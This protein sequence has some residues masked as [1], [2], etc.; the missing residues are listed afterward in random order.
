MVPD[1]V[2]LNLLSPDE[3]RQLLARRLGLGRIT[4]EPA[5]AD[6][7][8]EACAG[9]PLA[10]AVAAARA[11]ASPRLMLAGLAEE[12]QESRGGLDALD[13]GESQTNVRAVFSW[14]YRALS[15][16]AA[17][18]FRLLGLDACRDIGRS[19]AASLAAEA[20]PQA[21]VLLAE[22]ARAHLLTEVGHGRFVFHD[23]LRAYARELADAGDPAA[24]KHA[25][26][27]RLL[28]H[29]L[30]TAYRAD[31]LL[32]ADREDAIGLAP[33]T[34][35]AAVQPLADHRQARAGWTPSTR[36]CWPSC[37]RR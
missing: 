26:V 31:E 5:A 1:S 35:G 11:A 32:R 25:A 9:L 8:I 3:A 23:L 33:A 19:A 7:I 4:A 2:S 27:H 22:L 18:F 13:G 36:T 15:P 34:P 24:D 16:A 37:A 17:R 30:H 10:L 20:P 12:L 21:R 6:G 29:Y 28:D 14:S